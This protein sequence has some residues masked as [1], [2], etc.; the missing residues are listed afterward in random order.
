[1]HDA[2]PLPTAEQFAEMLQHAPDIRVVIPASTAMVVIANL[3]LALRHP[4]N[5]GENKEFIRGVIGTLARNMPKETWPVINEGFNPHRAM[6]VEVRP[7]A[8]EAAKGG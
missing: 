3:Q 1:M 5:F 6:R 7:Q 4:T 8:E 2:R